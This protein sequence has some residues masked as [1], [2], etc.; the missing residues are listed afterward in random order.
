MCFVFDHRKFLISLKESNENEEEEEDSVVSDAYRRTLIECLPKMWPKNIEIELIYKKLTFELLCEII[1]H[2]NWPTQLTVV[3]SLN[4]ILEKNSTRILSSDIIVLIESIINLSSRTKSSR[5]KSEILKLL[6]I[7]FENSHYSICFDE[8]ENLRSILQFNINE[9][10]HD[11]RFNDI[12]EQARQ[13]RKQHEH[14]FVKLKDDDIESIEITNFDRN[15][16][17]LF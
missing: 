11:N 8:N 9:V 10:I 7:L 16:I 5:L 17:D 2:T 15:D 6:K 13:L 12:S 14:L 3:H 1:H 4:L